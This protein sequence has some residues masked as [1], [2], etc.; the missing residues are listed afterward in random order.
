MDGREDVK[1]IHPAEEEQR[2]IVTRDRHFGQLLI[3]HAR[4]NA[5]IIYLRPGHIDP[6]FTLQPLQ[7]L[8]QCD[9]PDSP[10][11]ILSSSWWPS[12]RSNG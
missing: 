1:I 11:I 10:F 9:R 8:F 12:A 6:R 7:A 4:V 5:G 2:V 3:A